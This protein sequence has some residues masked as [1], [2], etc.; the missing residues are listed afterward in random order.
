M[1]TPNKME[2]DFFF[3]FLFCWQNQINSPIDLHPMHLIPIYLTLG[4]LSVTSAEMRN[5]VALKEQPESLGRCV[6]AWQ[7]H[8]PQSKV[9]YNNLPK[10]TLQG[11]MKTNT[12]LFVASGKG[13]HSRKKEKS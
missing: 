10:N 3:P 11:Q 5:V 1:P 9:S 13:R 7:A 8:W 4:P 2:T 6:V 12:S